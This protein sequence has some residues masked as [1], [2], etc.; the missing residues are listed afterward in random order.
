MQRLR[1][2]RALLKSRQAQRR[3]ASL[4]YTHVADALADRAVNAIV[5][6]VAAPGV[7]YSPRFKLRIQSPNKERV[8]EFDAA[9]KPQVSKG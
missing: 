9:R 5:Q 2:L 6:S 3:Y 1:W 8:A 4:N 7:Y